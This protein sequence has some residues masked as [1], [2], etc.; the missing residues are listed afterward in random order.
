MAEFTYQVIDKNGKTKKGNIEA[1]SLERAKSML[2]ADG[3]TII[4]IDEASLL[5]KEFS[6]GGGG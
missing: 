1:D 4:K 5:N 6:F 2:K 3:S